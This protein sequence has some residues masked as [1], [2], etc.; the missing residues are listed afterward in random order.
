MMWGEQ[1]CAGYGRHDGRLGPKFEETKSAP[2]RPLQDIWWGP[3]AA[4]SVVGG[5][6]EGTVRVSLMARILRG[7][8]RGDDCTPTKKG[9]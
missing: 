5:E 2:L 6:K 7:G 4:G 8:R 3:Q 1:G 9:D